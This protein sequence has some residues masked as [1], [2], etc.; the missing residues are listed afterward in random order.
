MQQEISELRR[1]HAE[2]EQLSH[3]ED[4]IN[5][6]INYPSLSIVSENIDSPSINICPLQYFEDVTISV[7]EASDK[8]QDVLSEEWAKISQTVTEVDVLLALEEPKTRNEFLRYS[9]QITLDSNTA[10]THLSLRESSR[11]IMASAQPYPS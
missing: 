2:M 8:L 4:R 9:H 5:F 3:T 1:K 7:S 10:N 6:L 11:K